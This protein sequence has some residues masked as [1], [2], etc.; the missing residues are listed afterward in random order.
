M[1]KPCFGFGWV[2]QTTFAKGAG[3]NQ[4]ELTPI[5]RI[6]IKANTHAL[7]GLWVAGSSIEM[8]TRVVDP[9]LRLEMYSSSKVT[10]AQ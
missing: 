7:S 6:P 2:S 3:N 9:K 8:H 4:P 5:A 10:Q 1:L